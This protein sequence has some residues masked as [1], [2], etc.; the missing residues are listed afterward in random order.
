MASIFEIDDP[1][2]RKNFYQWDNNQRL[3]VNIPVNLIEMVSVHF[4]S[5]SDDDPN[6][7]VCEPYLEDGIMYVD[8]PNAI[9]TIPGSIFVYLYQYSDLVLPEITP[10]SDLPPGEPILGYHRTHTSIK[11]EFKVKPREKPEDYVYSETELSDYKAVVKQYEKNVHYEEVVKEIANILAPFAGD[12]P[13]MTY[14]TKKESFKYSQGDGTISFSDSVG[15][16]NVDSG[17]LFDHLINESNSILFSSYLG[18]E[19]FIWQQIGRY[20]YNYSKQLYVKELYRSND[21]IAITSEANFNALAS[22]DYFDGVLADQG[23]PVPTI[24]ELQ[25]VAVGIEVTKDG[26]KIYI[27]NPAVLYMMFDSMFG[28]NKL[29][30]TSHPTLTIELIGMRT[31]SEIGQALDIL[32]GE[33]V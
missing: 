29:N 6:A 11:K 32:N 27:D 25:E 18:L 28:D 17:D 14:I 33:E 21:L 10:I 13:Y 22:S 2:G 26:A 7:S 23:I 12:L 9:L 31:A 15:Y 8:V 24:S 5:M 16:L 30:G 4:S 20:G 3:R 19:Y 1:M